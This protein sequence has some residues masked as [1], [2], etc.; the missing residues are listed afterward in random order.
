MP[1]RT[2][3]EQKALESF[4]ADIIIKSLR[5]NRL[6]NIIRNYYGTL[7]ADR[8]NVAVPIPKSNFTPGSYS[9]T[10]VVTS[11]QP[12]YDRSSPKFEGELVIEV[13]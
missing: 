9:L 2:G 7:S 12:P 8:K 3:T 10:M 6:V 5:N 13:V 1:L 11:V 4:K